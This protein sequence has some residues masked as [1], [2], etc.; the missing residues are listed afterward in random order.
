M[1]GA[2]T[3]LFFVCW[4]EHSGGDTLTMPCVSWRLYPGADRF[5]GRQ[6]LSSF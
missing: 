3:F 6:A 1:P 2:D 5:L 4:T